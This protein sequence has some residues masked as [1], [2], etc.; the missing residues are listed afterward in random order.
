[1]WSKPNLFKTLWYTAGWDL[2]LHW[3]MNVSSIVELFQSNW[4]RT[5]IPE[6]I[7]IVSLYLLISTL[8]VFNIYI[9]TPMKHEVYISGSA[10]QLFFL[11]A[12]YVNKYHRLI[13]W[14]RLTAL[15]H[16]FVVILGQDRNL[17]PGHNAL[18]F[19]ISP[20]GSFN[21]Q[22]HRQSHTTFHI[23]I[24]TEPPAEVT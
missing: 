16:T 10:K 21:C 7:N 6:L 17:G 4:S 1:M 24:A 15:S 5:L 13:E 22:N 2:L 8:S 11:P 19:L 18:L 3:T 12:Q 20:K 23:Y 9:F 14:I